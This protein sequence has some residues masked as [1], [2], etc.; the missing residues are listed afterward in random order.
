MIMNTLVWITAT[1]IPALP[2]LIPIMGVLIAQ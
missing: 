1:L 2:I